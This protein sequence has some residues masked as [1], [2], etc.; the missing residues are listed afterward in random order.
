MCSVLFPLS[1][2]T[3]LHITCLF[4]FLCMYGLLGLL[5]TSGENFMSTAPLE[6]HVLRKMVTCSILILPAVYI[7]E[8]VFWPCVERWVCRSVGSAAVL[9][10]CSPAEGRAQCLETTTGE[11]SLWDRTRSSWH[12]HTHVS[13]RHTDTDADDHLIIRAL[14]VTRAG[15][16]WPVLLWASA[17]VRTAPDETHGETE[18]LRPETHTH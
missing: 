13:F 9:F 6:I 10:L 7:Y 3:L 1:H 15:W 11:E 16:S 14:L 2:S 8:A 12:T 4:C 18:T 17:A 5:P